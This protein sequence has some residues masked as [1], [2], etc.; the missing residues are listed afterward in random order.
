[1]TARKYRDS[2]SSGITQDRD[3][4][5]DLVTTVMNLLVPYGRGSAD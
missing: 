2:R 1:V 5:R 4:W 3:R